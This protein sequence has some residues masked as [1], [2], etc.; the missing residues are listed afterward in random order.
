VDGRPL[1]VFAFGERIKEDARE[2]V[3]RLGRE[4]YTVYLVS[5]DTEEKVAD[6][7]RRLGIPRERARARLTPEGKVEMLRAL[8]AHD[9]LMVGD[10]LND[11]PALDAAT[12]AATPAV[13]HPALPGRADFY[14]LGEGVAAVR[15][16][17]LAAR[18][19]LSVVRGNLG[20]A[21]AYNAVA[22]TFCYLGQVTPV[23]AAVLMPASSVLIV[24]LTAWR[25]SARRSA[26]MS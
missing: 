26:W 9:T 16:A 19:L 20:L 17:L 10:G 11:G 7:A 18:H 14:F 13:D 22:H 24:S 2:E 4:G 21:A 8:D 12:C 15:R 3:E 1:A 23:V 6:A 5:G 25:L